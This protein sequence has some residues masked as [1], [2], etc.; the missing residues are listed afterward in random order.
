MRLVTKLR[1]RFESCPWNGKRNDFVRT[2]FRGDLKVPSHQP[3]MAYFTV[4]RCASSFVGLLLADLAL[5]KKIIPIDI[6]GFVHATEG[7]ASI[8]QQLV[9]FH[10]S[11]FSNSSTDKTIYKQFFRPKGLFFGPIRNPNCIDQV[12]VEDGTKSILMLRDP[13]DVLTSLYFSIIYSHAIPENPEAGQLLLRLR[14]EGSQISI[15]EYIGHLIAEWSESYRT[16]CSKLIDRPD[17]L[18]LKYENMVADFP[19]WFEQVTEFWQIDLSRRAKEKYLR[20][21]NFNVRRENKNAHKRKVT[22]GDFL[23]KLQPKTIEILNH[24]F[25]DVLDRLGYSTIARAAA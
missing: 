22:P 18:F 15:D 23:A 24:E 16:Y 3:S 13:R 9:G 11:C 6:E 4:H 12:L 25:R 8:D 10:R 20:R 14:D 2:L 19:S 1:R 7:S 17:V 5:E 21:A